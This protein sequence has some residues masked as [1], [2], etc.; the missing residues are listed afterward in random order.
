MNYLLGI[1]LGT[2]SLKVSI[3]SETGE[4]VAS[5]SREYAIAIPQPGYAEQ[6]PQAWWDGLVSACRGL[7]EQNP[8][9]FSGVIGIGICG[10]MH[11][12][13]YLDEKMSHLR[14]AITWMDQR[15]AAI[16]NRINSDPEARSLVFRETAN[17]AST[18]YTALHNRWVQENEPETW[19]SVRH[20]LVAK[21]Y[22]K[23]RLTG[24]MVTDFAE[25]SGTLVFDVQKECWS[26]EAFDFFGI[27]RQ[28]YPQ[29]L[30]SDEIIGTVS[31][32]AGR[33]TGLRAGI[34]VVNGSSDNSASA[35]GAGMVSPGQVTLIIG[36]AGVITVCSDHPLVDPLNR[37]LCWH[38]CLRQRWATLGIMQT[39]GESLEWFKNAFDRQ[40]DAD[41]SSRDIF[42]RYNE[43][44]AQVQEGS[45][46]LIFL[47]YLNGERTPYWDPN[48]RGVF[49]GVNLNTSKGHFVRAIMEGVSFG[50]RNNIETVESLGIQINEVRAVGGGL[51]SKVWLE[52]LGKVLRKPIATVSV[53]DTANLGNILL[54]GRALGVFPDYSLAVEKMV[55]TEH[56]V[57]HPQG[58][59]AYERQYPIFL[60]LY[61]KLQPLYS[62]AR[63]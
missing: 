59:E 46:G 39:A 51:K 61:Q 52:I 44:A 29:A 9:A 41:S 2:T 33:L 21:D 54:C 27:P 19:A 62:L 30:P 50:L 1:D 35:L 28:V 23:Y 25:A 57:W 20:I 47:P 55:S 6:D 7:Q 42:N 37:T 58:S 60:D 48:A 13:V 18:T 14:P 56:R 26:Q 16:V 36:T 17:A 40:Q 8:L 43:A 24:E 34:P 5:Q 15:S 31:A 63:E 22:L 53:S 12:Q 10:Q 45:G 4:L 32:E 3:Y 38:Y 49:F 11:T